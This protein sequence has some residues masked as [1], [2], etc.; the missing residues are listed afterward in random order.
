VQVPAN[1]TAT[2]D[3]QNT[4]ASAS[5]GM[6][7]ATAGTASAKKGPLPAFAAIFAKQ[8][9]AAR[10]E[11]GADATEDAHPESQL[12]A[13]L[14]GKAHAGSEPLPGSSFQEVK[15]DTQSAS[16][17]A[18]GKAKAAWHRAEGPTFSSISAKKQS[19]AAADPAPPFSIAVAQLSVETKPMPTAVPEPSSR[20]SFP[21][22]SLQGS[23]AQQQH[24]SELQSR[25]EETGFQLSNAG[26]PVSAAS[27]EVV[28]LPSGP[29]PELQR[30]FVAPEQIQ[31]ASTP[32]TQGTS[33]SS[34][35]IPQYLS[36]A[37]RFSTGAD[38]PVP[39]GSLSGVDN[40]IS[41]LAGDMAS[42]AVSQSSATGAAKPKTQDK[43]TSDAVRGSADSVSI[44]V[45]GSSSTDMVRSNADASAIASPTRTVESADTGAKQ[46]GAVPD[47]N[48]FQHLDAAEAPATILHSSAHQFSV[49]VHDPS[50]GWLEVQTQSSAGHISATLTAAS[51]EAHTSLAAQTPAITQYLAERNV[52]VHSLN[53][54]TQADTQSGASDGGQSQSG[55]RSGSQE[56]HKQGAVVA[57]GR[58]PTT[59]SATEDTNAPQA[60]GA[61][62]ISVRA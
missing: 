3:T 15:S 40:P 13:V 4:T 27:E 12:E 31:S 5:S 49:G 11:N 29:K 16:A 23:D 33:D 53:V 20:T 38:A 51:A 36:Q 39:A 43:T 55:P 17:S 45:R 1:A 54:Y 61:S 8:S 56:M 9:I 50:F 19:V 24:L 32:V 37:H 48:A 42:R 44:A 28:S 6:F 18:R 30:S 47:A 7:G 14:S 62:Y 57:A 60:S 34:I 2:G 52:S 58:L 46:G 10:V 22:S 59:L 35:S 25:K 41:S 26:S 21:S